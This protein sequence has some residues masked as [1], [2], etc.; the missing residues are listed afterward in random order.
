[1]VGIHDPQVRSVLA[2]ARAHINTWAARTLEQLG[3]TRPFAA[4][5]RIL[6]H[7]DGAILHT[8]TFGNRSGIKD[9]IDAIVRSCIG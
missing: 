2:E 6:D 8:L 7:L 4:A 5:D 9:D 1:M 3:I